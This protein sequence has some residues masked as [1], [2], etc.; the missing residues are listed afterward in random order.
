MYRGFEML[1]KHYKIRS[2]LNPNVH[3][4]YTICNCMKPDVY[5]RLV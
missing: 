1:G 3:R 5:N 4:H 2:L